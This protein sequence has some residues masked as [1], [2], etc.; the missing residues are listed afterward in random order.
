MQVR[1]W[2]NDSE[3]A[4]C[5]LHA[6]DVGTVIGEYHRRVRPRPD[7]TQLDDPNSVQ[8][9]RRQRTARGPASE[10]TGIRFLDTI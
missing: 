9:S 6:D 2:V 10:S 3:R 8:R 7:P 4:P 5:T 1:T